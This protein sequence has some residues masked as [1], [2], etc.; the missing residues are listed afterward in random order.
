M[1]GTNILFPQ[2]R[3]EQSDSK[4]PFADY[5]TL[6]S[7]NGGVSIA[8]DVFVDASFYPI[9]GGTAI[10]ISRI[11]VAINTVTVY[12][13]TV[14]PAVVVSATYD[15]LSL[16]INN[17]LPFYDSYNR[18]AGVLIFNRDRIAEIYQWPVGTYAFSRAAAE[19]VATAFV[20]SQTPGVRALT[21]NEKEFITGDV[22][23]V[24][25]GGVVLRAEPG[26]VI[27]VDV[28]GVPLFNRYACDEAQKNKLP[29]RFVST[30]NN[31]PADEFGNFTITAT[32]QNVET[33]DATV[34]R[35]YPTNY[36]LT[37]EAAGRS[38]V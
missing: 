25:E 5:A 16:P 17:L 7:A 13:T 14:A 15:P 4:Y 19:I 27:R 30:I 11:V 31:C 36:G 33:G 18:P 34:L 35:V 20:P 3:D 38:E 22:W 23:L 37:I 28:V 10:Y 1:S 9:G 24:G 21:V 32:N 29:T 2:F 12:A 6:Q 26:N 8:K